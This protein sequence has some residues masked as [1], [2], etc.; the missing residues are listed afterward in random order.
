M[1]HW[2]GAL[3]AEQDAERRAAIEELEEEK[4]SIDHAREQI[5]QAALGERSSQM[6][7]D[8]RPRLDTRT[9]R[10]GAVVWADQRAM[11]RV[12][13]ALA[14]ESPL[15]RLESKRCVGIL[16]VPMD[17]GREARVVATLVKA[18]ASQMA[19]FEIVTM[20]PWSGQ[21][22]G[23]KGH[24]KSKTK[25]KTKG[26]PCAKS[27]GKGRQPCGGWRD[28]SAVVERHPQMAI[29]GPHRRGPRWHMAAAGTLDS[30]SPWSA[31]RRRLGS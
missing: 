26:K 30:A 2:E 20:S 7:E 18:G 15:P 11:G 3:A 17:L 23:R 22:A 1:Q 12:V 8:L 28:R 14:E 21:A 24:G 16:R 27:I 19:M 25:G 29:G 9:T 31:G 10:S 6:G 4:A 13:S 5:A